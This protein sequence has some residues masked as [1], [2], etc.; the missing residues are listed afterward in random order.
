[1][2]QIVTRSPSIVARL[3]G[4]DLPAPPQR[5]LKPILDSPQKKPSGSSSKPG[6]DT[7]Q[8]IQDKHS[9][10]LPPKLKDESKLMQPEPAKAVK[11]GLV[12][13]SAA[14]ASKPSHPIQ[15]KLEQIDLDPYPT[16]PVKSPPRSASPV[17][18]EKILE[19]TAK[20]LDIGSQSIKSVAIKLGR[21]ELQEPAI[22]KFG[23]KLNHALTDLDGLK[24]TT[25][26]TN[27]KAKMNEQVTVGG[28]ESCMKRDISLKNAASTT[29]TKKDTQKGSNRRNVQ[30][31]IYANML[32]RP[33]KIKHIR[34]PLNNAQKDF[35]ALN[36][37]MIKNTPPRKENMG[38][39]RKQE[40][41]NSVKKVRPT[42]F[43][44]RNSNTKIGKIEG[45]NVKR[46]GKEMLIS[47]GV[48]L[49]NEKPPDSKSYVGKEEEMCIVSFTFS[50]PMKYSNR[51][52]SSSV[53]EGRTDSSLTES[54]ISSSALLVCI[55]LCF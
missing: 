37:S 50:A 35:I 27:N 12:Q 36:R 17:N 45:E 55:F 28:K 9:Q 31:N 48:G 24:T 26:S 47:K 54:S 46:G 21:S 18:N 5:T 40:N 8:I 43:N 7:S 13:N 22:E 51:Y 29:E 30:E 34:V 20:L 1:M 23:S 25:G 53:L 15:K 38:L 52:R 10:L 19:A 11:F 41:K 32:P 42:D 2:P 3:M 14:L 39:E 16:R 44:N 49:V 33:S 6:N 4:L